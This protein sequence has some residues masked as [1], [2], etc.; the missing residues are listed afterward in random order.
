[1]TQAW[2][3]NIRC[4][5]CEEKYR[6]SSKISQPIVITAEIGVYKSN[7]GKSKSFW[8]FVRALYLSIIIKNGHELSES[9]KK[10]ERKA[11]ENIFKEIEVWYYL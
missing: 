1:M 3:L 11:K 8:D 6:H 5:H 10:R 4:S 7:K 9:S 2:P